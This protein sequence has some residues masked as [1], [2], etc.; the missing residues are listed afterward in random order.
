MVG[1]V[2]GRGFDA[3]NWTVFRAATLQPRDCI[4]NT[5]ILLPTLLAVLLVVLLARMLPGDVKLTR[6]QPSDLISNDITAVRLQF[7]SLHDWR[8]PVRG[9]P[10]PAALYPYRVREF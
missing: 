9:S 7:P 1:Y 6:R 5:A 3:L 2:V 10:A 4:V 8:P